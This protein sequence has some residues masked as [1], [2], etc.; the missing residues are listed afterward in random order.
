MN[1]VRTKL[2][3]QKEQQFLSDLIP[4]HATFPIHKLTKLIEPEYS[5]MKTE[6]LIENELI[7]DLNYDG[8]DNVPRIKELKKLAVEVDRSY[9]INK[10]VQ[11]LRMQLIYG[12]EK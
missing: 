1:E 8:S 12:P 3:K 10:Q 11:K 2:T 4:G 9:V 5:K 7:A 6:A